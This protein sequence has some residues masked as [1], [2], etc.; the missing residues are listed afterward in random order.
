MIEAFEGFFFFV[1]F[2]FLLPIVFFAMLR[3][4]P[5]TLPGTRRMVLPRKRARVLVVVVMAVVVVEMLKQR[6]KLQ[7]T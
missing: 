5:I 3:E 2:S 1:F 7:P 6:V 4:S